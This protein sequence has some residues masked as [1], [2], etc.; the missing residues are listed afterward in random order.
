MEETLR[1]TAAKGQGGAGG[2]G[3]AASED[4]GL[5]GQR[6]HANTQTVGATERGRE[7]RG[8]LRSVGRW[9]EGGPFGILLRWTPVAA[10]A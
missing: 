5:V 4:G 1:S 2:R 3:A 10:Q 7:S 9:G 8:G 6:T